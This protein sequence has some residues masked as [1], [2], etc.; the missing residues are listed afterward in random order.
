MSHYFIP[1]TVWSKEE[2][3]GVVSSKEWYKYIF[4]LSPVEGQPSLLLF[5]V[6]GDAAK[7]V[8][9]I[10]DQQILDTMTWLLRKFTGDPTLPNPNRVIR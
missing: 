9:G 5:W 4:N 10:D 8:D 6:V 1:R 3:D 7:V 2:L